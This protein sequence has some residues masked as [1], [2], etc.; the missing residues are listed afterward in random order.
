MLNQ[1]SNLSV[2]AKIESLDEFKKIF[3]LQFTRELIKHSETGEVFELK[4]VL[5]KKDQLEK[6][7][8]EEA[9]KQEK[10][11][12]QETKR[13]IK[14][15]IKKKELP[16]LT[17]KIDLKEKIMKPLPQTLSVPLRPPAP[18]Q[19]IL[20]IPAPKL[21]PHLQYLIPIAK[22]GR[23]MDLPK[24]NPL[25]KDPAVRT[26]E[27]SPDEKVIVTGAMGTKPTS[28]TLTKEDVNKIIQK[29]SEETKIPV[30]EGI[31][32][33]VVGRLIL[34]AIISEVVGSKFMIKKMRFPMPRQNTPP[35]LARK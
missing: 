6:E 8:I 27:A 21:P 1:N 18:R 24:I 33:V 23:E 29:F 12:I 7:K 20:R 15:V 19:K 16:P 30:Q 3:L 17:K 28:I 9:E 10:E 4:N 11:R 22:K 25:I 13:E 5:E 34:S 26:I 32:R 2:K 35:Y 14:K 31:F